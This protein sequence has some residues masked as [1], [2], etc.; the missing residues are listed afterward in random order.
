MESQLNFIFCLPIATDNGHPLTKRP[1]H[2]TDKLSEPCDDFGGVY[3]ANH[4]FSVGL[5]C[6]KDT[7]TKDPSEYDRMTSGR[8]G[9]ACDA[10]TET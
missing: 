4:I 9:K 10:S 7:G 6:D 1:P 5:G 2:L 8:P 3:D